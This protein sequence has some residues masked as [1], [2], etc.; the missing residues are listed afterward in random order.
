MEAKDVEEMQSSFSKIY[1][2]KAELAERFYVH[3]FVLLPEVEHLFGNDFSKQKEMFASMLTYCLKGVTNNQ[4]MIHT[5]ISLAKTHARYR[6]GPREI[7]LA[8]KA[9]IAA[10]QDVLGDDLTQAQGEVWEQAITGVMQLLLSEGH[11][12]LMS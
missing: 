3:L 8:G 10:L 4:S 6:L 9:V 7:E 2:R 1:A 5:G 11:A 12:D